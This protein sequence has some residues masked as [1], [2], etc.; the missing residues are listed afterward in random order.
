MRLVRVSKLS[1][2]R[3]HAPTIL[4]VDDEVDVRESLQDLL[5]SSIEDATVLLAADADEALEILDEKDLDLLMSDYRMPGMD[6]LDLLGVVK[7]RKPLLPTILIT[8]FPDQEL[9]RRAIEEARAENFL[10]KPVRP[11]NLVEV[12]NAAILKGRKRAQEAE[13]FKKRAHLGG[14]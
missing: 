12:V 14:S 5:E 3:L 2:F 9:A 1:G 4:I 7:E 13:D 11:E 10:S 6:G 8:A